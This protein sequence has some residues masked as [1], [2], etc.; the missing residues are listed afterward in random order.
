MS[1]PD[2]MIEVY[3]ETVS[4]YDREQLD[5]LRVALRSSDVNPR[6]LKKAL[7][8]HI[9]TNYDGEDA[10]V[11][12]ADHFE[13]V[14]QK[15]NVPDDMKKFPANSSQTIIEILQLANMVSSSSE[16]RRLIDQGAV[17]FAD[18]KIESIDHTFESGVVGV[19]KVGKRKFLELI[20][21]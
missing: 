19:L 4:R 9:V 1:I 7:A 8:L 11:D 18:Q 6:D 14:F 10:A 13:S 12:A 2:S 16:A 21:E 5:A 20:I 17:K 15:G 3:A